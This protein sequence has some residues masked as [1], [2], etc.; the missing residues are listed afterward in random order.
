[1][2]RILLL[3]TLGLYALQSAAAEPGPLLIVGGGNV[4]NEVFRRLVEFGGGEN[5]RV[6]VVPFASSL[7]NA[8]KSAAEELRSFGA[9]S[10]EV[11]SATNRSAAQEALERATAIWF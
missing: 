7:T 3:L 9:R 2:N 6:L 4:P 1:M 11:L 5:A 10:V 8:G